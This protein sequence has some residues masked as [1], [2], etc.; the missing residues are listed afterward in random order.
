MEDDTEIRVHNVLHVLCFPCTGH[1]TSVYERSLFWIVGEERG[2][3]T[4][5]AENERECM[6]NKRLKRDSWCR[7]IDNL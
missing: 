7:D 5:T 2:S 6:I 4:K 3:L 1:L